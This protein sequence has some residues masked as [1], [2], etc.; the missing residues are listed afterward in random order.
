MSGLSV[1]ALHKARGGRPVLSGVDLAVRPGEVVALLGPSGAGK[2]T[3][4]RCV[5]GLDAPDGGRVTVDRAELTALAG[6]PLAQAR[7]RV[8]LVYQQFNLLRR[9]SALDN[10]LA[11]RL[12]TIPLWRAALRRFPDADRQAALGALDRVGLLDK[13][14]ARADRLSGGQQQRVA[15]AR[16]LVQDAALLLADE[17]VASLDPETAS[18]VMALLRELAAERG[19]A[20]LVSLHQVDQAL[21]FADRV[22]GLSAG[23]IAFDLPPAAVTPDRLR[24]LFGGRELPVASVVGVI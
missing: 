18:G 4:F 5:A 13:A 8:A 15:L 11:G 19:L 23:R 1:H 3:L 20:V 2:T 17:P 10:V 16:A 7:R 6:R 21:A 12:H 14:Y 24:T 22:L 9:L